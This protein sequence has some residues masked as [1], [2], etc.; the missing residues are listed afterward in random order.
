MNA[1]K[2]LMEEL[3]ASTLKDIK[4]GEVSKGTIAAI[5]AKEVIV[6]I[7]FKSEGFVPIE[8]F[9][10]PAELAV[11]QSIEVLIEN[12]EDDHG[13][14][15]FSFA[16]AERLKGWQKLSDDINE[17]DILEG[18][19]MRAV[20]GGYIVDV[21]GI[22][23]FL[24]MSLSAFKGLSNHDITAHNYKFVV[25][26]MNK[27]RRNLILSRREMVQKEREEVREKLWAELKK[28]QKRRGS[29]KGIT[30]FGAFIDLGEWMGF[31]IS[32]I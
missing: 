5:T 28:G 2:S 18:R 15:I 12:I 4:E 16:K 7:G 29:V 6:D 22:E 23:A 20:K 10:N 30:D 27:Q 19:V 1:E 8:E 21:F 11:G 9:R 26:K 13:R 32:L 25:A 31:C 24:P 17:G 3:Y 14:L